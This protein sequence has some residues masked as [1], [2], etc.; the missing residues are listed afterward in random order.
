MVSDPS[1]LTGGGDTNYPIVLLANLLKEKGHSV[2]TIDTENIKSYDKI[3]FFEFPEFRRTGLPNKYLRKLIKN[4]FKEMYLVCIEPEAIKPNNWVIKNH[5]YFKKIF[6]W[7][8]DYVDDKKYIR[9]HS[10]SHK[11]EEKVDFELEQ[12]TKLCVLIA[13]NKF[14]NHPNELYSERRKVIRWFEENHPEDFD[15]YGVGWDRYLP[16]GDWLHFLLHG[17]KAKCT[18]Y[19][20]PIPSKKEVLKKYRFAIC[21]ENSSFSGWITERIFSCFLTGCV[22]VYLGD[23]NIT[24]RIPQ[25][26]FIDMRQ[27]ESYSRLYDYLRNMTDKEYLKYIDAI[28]DFIDS[29]KNFSFTAEY[30]AETII[31]EIF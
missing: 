28:K 27:F 16:Q 11:K 24:K 31:K 19:R 12:K 14:F 8:D 15:L 18:S 30:F 9:V 20:G 3:I 13:R 5:R 29:E 7:Y 21:F 2:S 22:P 10:T 1:A 17:N 25:D 26:A 6:T 4:K 23:P